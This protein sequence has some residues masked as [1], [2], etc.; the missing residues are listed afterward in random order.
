[1]GHF[2]EGV[3]AWWDTSQPSG[4]TERPEDRERAARNV[5]RA[6]RYI[7]LRGADAFPWRFVRHP[8]RPELVRFEDRA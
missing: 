3:G 4:L 8:E 2:E 1:M 5:Q 6:L 7:G